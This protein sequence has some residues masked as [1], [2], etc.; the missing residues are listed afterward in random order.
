MTHAIWSIRVDETCDVERCC[1]GGSDK[2]GTYVGDHAEADEEGDHA[3]NENEDFLALATTQEVGVNVNDGRHKAL[4][5]HELQHE[6]KLNPLKKWLTK[7]A[8]SLHVPGCP[9]RGG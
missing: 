1:G 6:P 7:Y 8:Q 9:N 5:T 3:A 4:Y 2:V